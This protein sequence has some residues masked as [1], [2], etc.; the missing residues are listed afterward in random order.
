MSV[1]E[2]FIEQLPFFLLG[3]AEIHYHLRFLYPRYFKKEPEI[4][5]DVPIRCQ[6]FLKK[7]FPVL[8]IIKDSDKYPLWLNSISIEII[9][10]NTT[11]NFF[12]K[13]QIDIREK[14]YSRIFYC[15]LSDFQDDQFI[16]VN[17]FFDYSIMGNLK[18]CCNDNFK[19]LSSKPFRSYLCQE[20]LPFPRNWF[21]GDTHYHSIHTSD[22]V[23]FGADIKSTKVMAQTIGLNWL[24][25]TDHSYDLDD[26]PNDCTKNDPALPIW[27]EM[28][29]NCQ[30]NDDSDLRIIAGEEISIGNSKQK[31]VHLL[32]LNPACFYAGHGDSAER[33]FRNTPTHSLTEIKSEQTKKNLFIAAHPF[34]KIPFLQKI[35]LR[36]GSWTAEDFSAAGIEVIQIVNSNTASEIESVIKKWT[37]LLLTDKRVTIVAGNDAHGNFNL[38]RQIKIPFWNLFQSEKQV[39]G[40]FFTAFQHTINDPIQGLKKGR[41][42]ISNGPFLDFCLAA[43]KKYPIGSVCHEKSAKIQFKAFSNSEFGKITQLTVHIG[44]FETNS[45]HSIHNIINQTKLSLPEKGYVRMSLK[46]KENCLAFTNPIWI[47]TREHSTVLTDEK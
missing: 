31:N 11:R 36:R 9:C 38:M 8:I 2:G 13:L 24:F 42:I 10:E 45:E 35:T 33:W 4:I 3:Y 20:D 6:K 26:D 17:V 15:D 23:E 40:R 37:D 19:T 14:Y 29:Q 41:V 21:C 47:E 34:E 18:R 5:A 27:K 30:Q 25:I 1:W 32:A 44:N 16:F 12:H 43:D 7:K 28:I 46:T 39:F 22:Q